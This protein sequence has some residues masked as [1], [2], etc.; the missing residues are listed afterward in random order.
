MNSGLDIFFSLFPAIRFADEYKSIS[1]WW[2]GTWLYFSIQLGMSSSQ[3]TNSI[4]FQVGI[5]TTN[6]IWYHILQNSLVAVYPKVSHSSSL[7]PDES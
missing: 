6:Q 3:L 1:D 5:P 2:F 7:P 4:I